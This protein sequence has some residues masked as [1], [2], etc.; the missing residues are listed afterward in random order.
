V[1]LTWETLRASTQH[2][3]LSTLGLVL[4]LALTIVGASA[5][6][7]WQWSLPSFVIPTELLPSLAPEPTTPPPA[8]GPAGPASDSHFGEILLIVAII[9]AI[10]V[11]ALWGRR[12]VNRYRHSMN[13]DVPPMDT[14]PP[15]VAVHGAAIGEV[16]VPVLVDAVQAALT[17]LDEAPSSHDAV[18]GAWIELEKAAARHGWDKNVAE[19]S[20]EFTTRLLGVS[21]APPGPTARLR[22][23]YQRARFSTMAVNDTDVAVARHAL[24]D[25]A[26]SLEVRVVTADSRPA[27]AHPGITDASLKDTGESQ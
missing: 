4:V 17:R 22:G 15:S 5:N 21:P 20:T 25:I 18:V 16:E 12:I 11:L 2:K 3:L 9:A 7:P 19:T 1:K 27:T 26:R 10:L 6:V 13:D 23:L 14:P 8:D 24:E